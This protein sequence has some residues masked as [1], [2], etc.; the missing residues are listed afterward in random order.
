MIDKPKQN[1]WQNFKSSLAHA[2]ALNHGNNEL[3]EKDQ[4]LVVQICYEVRRR[5]MATPAIIALE[6]HRPF[7]AM[8][9]YAIQFFY[10]FASF[11]LN[12]Q[13]L[14]HL[15]ELFDKP[16]TIDRLLELLEAQDEDFEI[17]R[18]QY[19]IGAEFNDFNY[20]KPDDLVN[21][22]PTA[23]PDAIP[24]VDSAAQKSE[25]SSQLPRT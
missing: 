11:F 9:P 6:M 12:K 14:E 23:Q 25:T 21:A 22:E 2:F 7:Q 10:P 16:S 24:V 18:K 15:T 1:W 4:K 5:K 8:G 3:T 13:F 17:V 19:K 20:V